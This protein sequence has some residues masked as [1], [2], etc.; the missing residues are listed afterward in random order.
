MK[1]S[2]FLI[3]IILVSAF[4]SAFAEQSRV[5]LLTSLKAPKAL[6]RTKDYFEKQTE[7]LFNIAFKYSG[8]KT[9]IKHR[10]DQVEL[11]KILLDYRTAGV[12]WVSHSN[13]FIKLEGPK[14]K[15]SI[16]A[17]INKLNAKQI[18]QNLNPNLK[19]LG[20]IGCRAK[21]MFTKYNKDYFKKYI[22]NLK[23]YSSSKKLSPRKG[24][25]NAIKSSVSS[26]GNGSERQNY[27][28]VSHIKADKKY[29][30]SEIPQCIDKKG[31]KVPIK[32]IIKKGQKVNAVKILF[33]DKEM[34]IGTLP[35]VKNNFNEDLI[36]ESYIY[37]PV[38][39]YKR[40]SDL[41]IHVESMQ[42]MSPQTVDFGNLTIGDGEWD[43]FKMRNGKA[44]GYETN[45][46]IYKGQT[47]LYYEISNYQ[48]YKCQ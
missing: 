33:N 20:L 34:L 22:P 36:Q 27:F 29:L 12:F 10:V 13:H 1:N 2:L 11:Q 26:L 31:Y 8:Y 4:N 5:Y 45:F 43:M 23:I 18:F 30:N 17:D 21:S 15:R 39:D 46:Y 25:I 16:V 47:Q 38:K 19:F 3:L 7:K 48:F 32:R 14:F 42:K 6:L 35:A 40:N 24:M 9:I 28:I 44:F 41:N 37:L